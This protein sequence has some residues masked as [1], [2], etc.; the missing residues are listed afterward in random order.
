MLTACSHRRETLSQEAYFGVLKSDHKEI[1]Q[2]KKFKDVRF[3][4][5]YRPIEEIILDD[6]GGRGLNDSLYA[7]LYNRHKDLQYYTLTLTSDRE[8]DVLEHYNGESETAYFQM[9]DYLENGIQDNIYLVEGKDTLPCI[10]SHYE[11]N[12]GLSSQN[13]VSLAFKSTGPDKL[14]SVDKVLVY[15]DQLFNTG[16]MQF[17]ISKESLNNLPGLAYE[18]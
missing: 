4:F 5:R 9:L 11:R 2:E 6:C 14:A 10:L 18:K 15:D 8:N 13:N 12:F 16:I 3:S 17:R 7:Q 1:C